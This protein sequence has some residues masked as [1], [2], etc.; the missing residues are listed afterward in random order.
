MNAC[1]IGSWFESYDLVIPE[2]K[3]LYWRSGTSQFGLSAIGLANDA[4]HIVLLNGLLAD[5]AAHAY[6][7]SLR[8]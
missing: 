8:R 7:M 1:L 4:A 3:G 5:F 6:H 2:T